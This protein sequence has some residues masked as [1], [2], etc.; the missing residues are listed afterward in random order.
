MKKR[1]YGLPAPLPF[2]A[3]AL[4]WLLSGCTSGAEPVSVKELVRIADEAGPGKNG[5]PAELDACPL[6]YDIGK[7]AEA[8]GVTAGSGAGG[9]GDGPAATV[10]GGKY[11]A[12]GDPLDVNPGA[13]VSC[14]FRLGDEDVE[15][16]TIGTERPSAL[17][18]LAPAIQAAAKMR[19]EDLAAYV[20]KA[21]QGAPGTPLVSG[22]G[23]VASVPLKDADGGSTG[24]VVAVAPDAGKTSLSRAQ[25][26][27]LAKALVS[28]AG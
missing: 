27:G 20:D 10:E 7:A 22:S 9:G 11:A 13:L 19:T 5:K 3:L 8:A 14:A 26:E 18:V 4:A 6:P 21:A 24:L 1:R 15:V 28:Q 25:I 23:N 2:A 16:H 12:S 17:A